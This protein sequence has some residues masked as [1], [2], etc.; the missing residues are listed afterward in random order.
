MKTVQQVLV[1]LALVLAMTGLIGAVV[2]GFGARFGFWEFGTGFDILKWAVYAAV[3]A[4][5]L[6]ITGAVLAI[7]AG[8]HLLDARLLAAAIVGLSIA[9]VTYSFAHQFKKTPTVADATTNIEDPP[10]FVALVAVREKTA[11]N[12][13]AYRRDEAADLQRRYFPDLTAGAETDRTPAEAIRRVAAVAEDMGW[14]IVEVAPEEGRLE[15]TD[16]TFWYGFKDDIVVRAR[17]QA[18]DK[19]RIDA[20]SASRVGFL[21]GGLN[22]RR[23]QEFLRKLEEK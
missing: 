14:E 1:M 20:R 17:P 5:V 13:L 16:T 4:V 12:P 11:K 3:A 9:G 7:P 15:A 6:A 10:S 2:S 18:N 21:D 22:A 23:I 19:T 8:A